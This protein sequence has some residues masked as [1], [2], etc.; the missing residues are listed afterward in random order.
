MWHHHGNCH[1]IHSNRVT[2]TLQFYSKEIRDND[3]DSVMVLVSETDY[4]C[5]LT[6]LKMITLQLLLHGDAGAKIAIHPESEPPLP[7]EL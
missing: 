7:E 5:N 6:L 3:K 4:N 1:N 2:F